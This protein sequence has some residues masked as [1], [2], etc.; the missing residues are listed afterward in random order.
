[1]RDEY[2]LAP[3][4]LSLLVLLVV[5]VGATT[6]AQ[7]SSGP[8]KGTLILTGGDQEIGI[9]EF[10]T[11]A[12]GPDAN[13]VY[14]P[15]A[16]SSLRLPS[17]LIWEW[18]YTDTLPANTPEF[19]Q[20]LCKMFGVKNITILHTRNRNTADSEGF[21]EPLHK[22]NGVWFSGGNPGRLSQAYL[23][24]RTQREIEAVLDRGVWSVAIRQGL[25]FKAPT[26]S[27]AIRT[28]RC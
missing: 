13:I 16:A 25:L 3:S 27:E 19:Q 1:M 23:G 4:K 20:E 22:A 28:S 17:G 24:T 7:I 26:R 5:L 9:K 6:A 8:A 10:V 11:L 2:K 15:T 21:V 14:I 18:L 12:G